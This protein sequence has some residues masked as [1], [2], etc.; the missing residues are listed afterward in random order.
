MTRPIDHVIP[1]GRH[2][3][4]II[5]IYSKRKNWKIVPVLWVGWPVMVPL[6]ELSS[7][8]ESQL[9]LGASMVCSLQTASRVSIAAHMMKRN[10]LGARLLPCFTLTREGKVCLFLTKVK[11]NSDWLVEKFDDTDE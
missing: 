2:E 1:A 10:R 8:S 7:L 4:A 11:F 3:C 6:M 5:C 9:K